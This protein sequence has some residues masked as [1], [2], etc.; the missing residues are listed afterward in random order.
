M[1]KKTWFDHF[2]PLW[3]VDEPAMFGHFW[4]I[5]IPQ[6]CSVDPKVKRRLTTRSFMCGLLIEPQSI[7]F[8][9]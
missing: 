5:P 4:A 7:L 6:S 3:N 8:G 2:G 1:V 9:T